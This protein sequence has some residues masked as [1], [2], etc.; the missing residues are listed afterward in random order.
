MHA[1]MHENTE[2][3]IPMQLQTGMDT[4]RQTVHTFSFLISTLFDLYYTKQSFL[5]MC[6]QYHIYI[7]IRIYISYIYIRISSE[8]H[9]VCL[10]F[11][12]QQ[13]C[14]CMY[15]HNFFTKSLH[16]IY[17]QELE[18]IH[19]SLGHTGTVA[20]AWPMLNGICSC[21]Y[22]VTNSV[23]LLEIQVQCMLR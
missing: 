11:I 9:C 10:R 21:T 16:C 22:V 8:L 17:R 14:H 13:Y 5:V 18:H 7:Y 6:I 1:N 20:G 2:S 3:K 4:H 12:T 19:S 23:P 15:L